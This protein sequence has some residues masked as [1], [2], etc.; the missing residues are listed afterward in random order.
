MQSEKR[1]ILVTGVPRSG[2]TAVGQMLA[3]A[4][5]AG[6]L[7]EPFNYHS[8][9][10]QIEHYFEIPG[11]HSFSAARLDETIARIKKLRLAF[12]PGI[13]PSDT[14]LRR[15]VK[16]VIGARPLNSYRRLRL[17]PNLRTIIWK[18]PLACF[19]A[20]H[21]AKQHE[22]KVLV[23]LR[24]PWA[25]AGSFKRME[26]AFDLPDLAARLKQIGF[27]FGRELA[28][29]DRTIH[30]SVANAALL[31]R[32][33]YSTLA[34]WAEA[35][36]RI[37][38]LNLDDVVGDPVT[39]YSKLYQ[40]LALDWSARIA[41]KIATHYRGESDR[42]VPKEKKAHDSGRNVAEVN[43]YW[44][45]YLTEAEKDFVGKLTKERWSE[46]QKICV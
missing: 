1:L 14:G 36:P 22:V 8:G 26:W 41:A 19:A 5:D 24:N 7:H 6:A 45:G 2:T 10:K 38:L 40:L 9:L 42:S 17:H 34:R 13:F 15:A 32:M 31:W 35:N 3:L 30:A 33:I 12:K 27:D 29:L 25:V 43:K 39:T 23:T 4:P 16:Y 46:F 37:H 18:D 11:A 44:R 20:N 21:A 28:G